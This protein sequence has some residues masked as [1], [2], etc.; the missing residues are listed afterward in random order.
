MRKKELL[1]VFGIMAVIYGLII[2]FALKDGKKCDERVFLKDGTTIDCTN[3]SSFDSGMTSIKTCEGERMEI[4][5][6]NIKIIKEIN[7]GN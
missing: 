6:I 2:F 4:P 1:G 5:T 7:N 3:T